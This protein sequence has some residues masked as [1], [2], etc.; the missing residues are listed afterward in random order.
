MSE[1]GGASVPGVRGSII[2]RLVLAALI[3]WTAGHLGVWGVGGFVISNQFTDAGIRYVG[4]WPLPGQRLKSV[5][6]SREWDDRSLTFVSDFEWRPDP[7]PTRYTGW[8]APRLYDLS[9]LVVYLLVPWSLFLA[10]LVLRG[11]GSRNRS[12]PQQRPTRT[13]S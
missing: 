3:I 6:V 11:T 9:E 7:D 10:M 2:R 1:C 12:A 13:E 5:V 8:A 4:F